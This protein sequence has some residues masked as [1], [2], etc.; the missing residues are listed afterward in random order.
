[1]AWTGR[2]VAYILSKRKKPELR[3][4]RLGAELDRRRAD[5]SQRLHHLLGRN[6]VLYKM[7]GFQVGFVGALTGVNFQQADVRR[8]VV[9]G[10]NP[11]SSRTDASTSS[12][13]AAL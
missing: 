5:K 4:T 10:Q 9:E 3:K 13:S 6:L 2:C 7:R 1:L 11:G 8:I 12:A